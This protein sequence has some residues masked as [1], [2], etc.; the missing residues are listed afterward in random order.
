MHYQLDK[1]FF[2]IILLFILLLP[3][4]GAEAQKQVILKGQLVDN[5]EIDRLPYVDIFV[6][7]GSKR[8]VSDSLGFFK[9]SL[10]PGKYH[11]SFSILGYL[12][13]YYILNLK[14]DTFLNVALSPDKVLLRTIDVN[15]HHQGQNL[16]SGLS[17]M[18]LIGK[19]EIDKLPT[20]LGETDLISALKLIPGVQSGGEGGTGLYVRGGGAG[21]NLILLDNT[22]VYNPS[23]LMGSFPVFNSDAISEITFYKA[24]IP[25]NYGGKTS[26]VIDIGLRESDADK[27]TG[28]GSVGMLSSDITLEAPIFHRH[29]SFVIS[30]RKSYFGIIK[31]VSDLFSNSSDNFYSNN[32]YSF[33]DSNAKITY[34]LNPRDKFLITYYSGSDK[35][36]MS[37]S[38]ISMGNGMNWSNRLLSLK[39]T[40]IFNDKLMI[41]TQIH[42]TQYKFNF[43][44]NFEKYNLSFSSRIR[45]RIGNIELIYTPSNKTVIKFGSQ[46][47]F[48]LVI[49]TNSR[50][51]MDETHYN[52]EHRF[53]SDE[54]STYLNL[55][56]ELSSVISI[57]TGLR[58]TY[59]RQLGPFTQYIDKNNMNSRDSVFFGK[60]EI[61]KRYQ[62][63]NPSLFFKFRLNNT[64]SIKGSF[65]T[66]HQFIHLASVGAVSLPTDIWLPSTSN[67]APQ[68]ASIFSVGFFK[69]LNHNSMHLGI[70]LFYKKLHNQ[71]ELKNSLFDFVDNMTNADNFFYG[72]GEAYGSEFFLKANFKK[73][74]S[75]LSY[76]LSRTL[77]KFDEINNGRPF[78]AKYDRTHDLS[79]TLNRILNKKW[80]FSALFVYN[81]GNTYTLPSGIYIIQGM[82]VVTQ[83]T[84]ANAY[85]MPPYHRLD[86]SVNYRFQS[87]H[88]AESWLN[89]SVYNVYNHANPFFMFFDVDSNYEKKYL[90]VSPKLVTLFPIIPSIT[91]NF[92]F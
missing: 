83:Y 90:N 17:G 87:K 10:N 43:Q 61:V 29:G 28:K 4:S 92:K 5:N 15:A 8:I 89:F 58:Y 81:T 20:F 63:L 30:G 45:D 21:Q 40:H 51:A 18:Y 72:I 13:K 27:L 35:Y 14:K 74:T 82:F 62:T 80:E 44:A 46:Y 69:D 37:R 52:W 55:D 75:Q 64:T 85:R 49:P 86:L 56:Y 42:Q 9:I 34:R 7:P 77:R 67:I 53:R 76:T 2:S 22:P 65:S 26:S 68:N 66:S 6:L 54:F 79:L 24:A 41:N 70:E 84:S 78:P 36:R 32:Q 38:D 11:V 12:S 25:S 3:G 39:H 33:F 31:L 16:H 1:N 19:K 88:F 57:S 73:T 60:N 23:H 48:H 71:I 59:Y 50:I 91:F 47:N